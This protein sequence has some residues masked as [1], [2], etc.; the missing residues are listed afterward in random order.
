M[1]RTLLGVVK[2]GVK[3]LSALTSS[4]PAA[5]AQSDSLDKLNVLSLLAQAGYAFQKGNAKRG[6]I[7]LGAATIAPKNRK[8]SYLV[9]GALT[10]DSLRK[11]LR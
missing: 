5:P 1:L 4:S 10:L 8:L 9:Q 2:S 11:R 3:L 7:L 6:A